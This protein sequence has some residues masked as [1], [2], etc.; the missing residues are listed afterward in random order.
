[1]NFK[2]FSIKKF[3]KIRN[4]SLRYT[5]DTFLESKLNVLNSTFNK[6]MNSTRSRT[7]LQ[8]YP[9]TWGL[10]MSSRHGLAVLD[11]PTQYSGWDHKLTFEGLPVHIT[12]LRCRANFE[13]LRFVPAIQELGK[14]LV[15][16]I[17]AKGFTVQSPIVAPSQTTAPQPWWSALDEEILP[18]V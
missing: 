14:S 12:K 18:G 13:G 2:A 10:A 4:A 11:G 17:R 7:H 6:W 3:T 15:E 9:A 5:R 8:T 16:R 1:L